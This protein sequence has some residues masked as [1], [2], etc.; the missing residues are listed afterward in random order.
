MGMPSSAP[1]DDGDVEAATPKELEEKLALAHGVLTSLERTIRTAR[2]YKRDHPSRQEASREVQTRFDA[3]FQKFSCLRLEVT[4]TELKMQGKALMKCEARDPEPPFRLYKDGVRE[5]R[6]HRGLDPAELAAFL[7]ILEM[8]PREMA[9]IELDLVSLLWSKDFKT[10]DHLTIDELEMSQDDSPDAAPSDLLNLGQGL[11]TD[12]AAL[13]RALTTTADGMPAAV[14]ASADGAAP[15]GAGAGGVP[16]TA[17][18][19]GAGGASPTAA[20]PGA[21][22]VPSTA[23]APTGARPSG[24]APAAPAAGPAG[25][26]GGR[27]VAPVHFASGAPA[28]AAGAAAPALEEVEALL[29]MPTAEPLRAMRDAVEKETLAALILRTIR[30]LGSCLGRAESV[31][32]SEFGPL[33]KGLLEV[34]ARKGDFAKV[35]RL[36]KQ[37]GEHDLLDRLQGGQG[38]WKELL[39]RIQG[40]E[41]RKLFPAFLGGELAADREGLEHYLQMAGPAL[42]PEACAVYGKVTDPKLRSSLREYIKTQGQSVPIAFKNLLEAPDEILSEVFELLRQL[43]PASAAVDLDTAFDRLSRTNKAEAVAVAA[44]MEGLARVRIFKR[45]FGDPDPA[46]RSQAFRKAGET[47]APDLA[48]LVQEWIGREEFAAVAWEEKLL[49]YKTYARLAGAGSFP[50]LKEV[51]GRKPSLFAGARSSEARRAAVLAL[52]ILQSASAQGLLEEWSAGADR[53]LKEFADEALKLRDASDTMRR[54]A[55]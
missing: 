44:G 14:G 2:L 6:F 22:N 15:A 1:R 20:G 18:G 34:Y 51:A 17:A 25:T 7:A 48:R 30:L 3:F 37:L 49:A 38:L 13:M 46:V 29:R 10:I 27:E 54:R 26:S 19:P 9:E 8:D 31:A 5:I 41:I 23:A 35:G 16:S 36:M 55:H 11:R 53:S 21:A 39:A 24:G 50:F 33:L 47:P 28:L 12:L 40:P 32:A 43:K 45:A 52:G 42:V 4:Q